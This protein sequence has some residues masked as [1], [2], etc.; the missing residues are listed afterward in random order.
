MG[1]VLE[2]NVERYNSVKQ[3]TNENDKNNKQI[4]NNE[5]TMSAV[6]K[7]VFIVPYR[8]REQHRIFFENYIPIIMSDYNREDW[9]YY[10]IHQCDQRPFNR[11]A[12]KNI[13]F[14]AIK[15]KYPNDYKNI[16]FVFN[17]VDTLPYTKNVLPYETV[18]GT[19]RHFYG[20][21]FA[22]GGIFTIKGEDFEK[23]NGFTNFWGWGC[24]DNYMQTRVVNARLTIDRGVFFPIGD[25]HILQLVDGFKRL[26]CRSEAAT[27]I[28]NDNIDGLIT[29]KN[30]NYDI[31]GNYVNVSTFDTAFSPETLMLEEQDVRVSSKI[32]IPGSLLKK[33][34]AIPFHLQ[35]PNQPQTQPQTQNKDLSLLWLQNNPANLNPRASQPNGAGCDSCLKTPDIQG[36]SISMGFSATKP[37]EHMLRHMATTQ[38]AP[39]VN[40]G[41]YQTTST[42]QLS[43][44][45]TAASFME[46]IRQHTP[47]TTKT[48]S[49][50]PIN[51]AS[52]QTL[53]APIIQMGIPNDES[54]LSKQQQIIEQNR[55]TRSM[56]TFNINTGAV[57][58]FKPRTTGMRSIFA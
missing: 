50:M 29:I 6:P 16:N 10:F 20:F 24:E 35:G 23:T 51:M 40:A 52:P 39:V 21:T 12:M 34:P 19:V 33:S 30:L 32:K 56:P 58:R 4:N 38:Y 14:L 28:T 15:Y 18:A 57:G 31:V 53:H 22:L 54:A 41:P 47:A 11:G 26:I 1:F 3:I 9:E 7:I 17:D 36:R 5:K 55:Q 13:G 27:T 43:D 49:M 25:T 48:V 44:G 46:T 37:S 2:K 45:K 8:D 42:A